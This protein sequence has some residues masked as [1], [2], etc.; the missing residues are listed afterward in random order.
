LRSDEAPLER[1]GFGVTAGPAVAL[2]VL[3]GAGVA[4]GLVVNLRMKKRAE[5]RRAA[6]AEAEALKVEAPPMPQAIEQTPAGA[7]LSH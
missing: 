6:E 4:V 1:K 3:L 2:A 7:G 5:L